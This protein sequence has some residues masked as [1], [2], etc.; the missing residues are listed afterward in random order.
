MK[1]NILILL[2]VFFISLI[3]GCNNKTAPVE[4]AFAIAEHSQTEDGTWT[5]EGRTY[6]YKVE[7]TGRDYNAVQDGRF[8]VLTNDPD[9]TYE[10]V[11]W[12]ILSSQSDDSLDPNETVIVEM[13]V[14][15]E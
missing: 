10:E 6:Q 8:V 4:N 1:R 11:S 5:S 13:G 3:V 12:S 7:L 14:V 9:I 15:E 2:A